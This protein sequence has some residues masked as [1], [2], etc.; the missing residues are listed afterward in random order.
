MQKHGK[1]SHTSQKF[2]LEAFPEIRKYFNSQNKP[3]IRYIPP[4]NSH[5][6][7]QN[8]FVYVSYADYASYSYAVHKRSYVLPVHR[9]D[10]HSMEPSL[11][12][13]ILPFDPVLGD[14]S[15]VQWISLFY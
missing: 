5:S 6:L 13:Q 3:A 15:F 1:S 2:V 4:E 8:L 9:N 7:P 12:S 10:I 14:V 11:I